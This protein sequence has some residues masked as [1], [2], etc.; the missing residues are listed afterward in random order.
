MRISIDDAPA[1]VGR[2]A[3]SMR[4][5]AERGIYSAALRTQQRIV[6]ELIPKEPARGNNPGPPVD[7][8]AYRAGWHVD[9]I[10][11]GAYLYNSAPHAGF[12]EWGVRAG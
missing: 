4:S 1:W 9:R 3:L 5:A 8:G 7:T 6:T 12:I 11:G 2:L 10:E